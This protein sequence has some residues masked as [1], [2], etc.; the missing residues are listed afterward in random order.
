MIIKKYKVLHNL[1]VRTTVIKINMIY[2]KLWSITYLISVNHTSCCCD[3]YY[4][5]F[6]T[7]D[8][9]FILIWVG[10]WSLF[11][12]KHV[13]LGNFD[14]YLW[15]FYLSPLGLNY[16]N[17]LKVFHLPSIGLN[18]INLPNFCVDYFSFILINLSTYNHVNLYFDMNWIL[19]TLFLLYLVLLMLTLVTLIFIFDHANYIDMNRILIYLIFIFDL[20]QVDLDNDNDYVD[21]FYLDQFDLPPHSLN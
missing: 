14:I 8:H 15:S 11:N 13:D 1:L 20:S 16:I 4:L 10:Y 12:L 19:I 6:E 9:I 5:N 3:H 7:F 17:L 21:H 18:E 2:I